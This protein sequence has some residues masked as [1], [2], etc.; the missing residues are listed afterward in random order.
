MN[1]NLLDDALHALNRAAAAA[2]REGQEAVAPH[3]ILAGVVS[4][5]DPAFEDLCTRMDLEVADLPEAFRDAP[6]TYEGHLPF[7]DASHAVLTAA[8]D[9]SSERE[10]QG[11]S[12]LHLFVGLVKT[13]TDD[14]T[15]ALA[16]WDLDEDILVEEVEQAFA[17]PTA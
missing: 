3:H 5:N 13:P 12:S 1:I 2:A 17:E 10:H 8:V 4:E 11:V 14:V 16:V 9:Y 6:A 15:A 7:T